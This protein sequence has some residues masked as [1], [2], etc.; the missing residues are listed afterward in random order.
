MMTGIAVDDEK[1]ILEELCAMIR[2]TQI[3]LLK[4]F[5]IRL[6]RLKE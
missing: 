5:Q 1:I 3:E 2:Q 6:R 4:A